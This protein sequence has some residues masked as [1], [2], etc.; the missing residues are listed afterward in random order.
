[1]TNIFEDQGNHAKKF[2]IKG[3]RGTI[4]LTNGEH[5]IKSKKIKE[6]WEH[7]LHPSWE[8]LSA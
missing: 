4:G 5:G 2:G 1:M 7:V 3:T 6:S 8:G